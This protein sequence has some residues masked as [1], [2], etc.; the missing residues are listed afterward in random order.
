LPDVP[1]IAESAGLSD[2]NVVAWIGLVARAGTPPELLGKLSAEVQKAI[3]SSEVRER[4][5]VLGMEPVSSSPAELAR[6]M[7]ESYERFGD[8]IRRANIKIE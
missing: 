7:N 3:Q 1:T 4:F 5:Q 8:V 2:F 6:V